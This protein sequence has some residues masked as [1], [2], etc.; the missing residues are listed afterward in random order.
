MKR[1][2]KKV[3]PRR[4]VAPLLPAYHLS[5]AVAA[6]ITNGF[7]ARRLKVIGVTGTNGKTTTVL[8]IASIL[9]AAGYKVGYSTSLELRIGDKVIEEKQ[10]SAAG[11]GTTRDAFILQRL[12]KRMGAAQL[13]WVVLEVTSHA[14]SQH[15]TWGIPVHT[16]VMTNLTEDH[17]DYHGTMQRYM[18]AKGKLFRAARRHSVLNRDDQYFDYFARPGKAA[19][20]SYGRSPKS[21]VRLAKTKLS[22]DGSELEISYGKQRVKATIHLPS[23][24]NIYN[25]LSAAATAQA[26]GISPESIQEGLESLRSIPGRMESIDTT[27][28]FRVIIDYAH[29]PDAFDQLFRSLRPVTKGQLIAVFGGNPQHDYKG[30]GDVAGGKTDVVIVTDDEPEQADPDEIR[31][32]IIAAAKDAGGKQIHDIADRR[33]AIE[34]AVGLAK[35]DDIVLLLCMGSQTYRRVGGKKMPWSD[36]EEAEKALRKAK[37]LK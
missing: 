3:L 30:L 9:R 25:A 16:A 19:V 33:K 35:K 4:F 17:L 24:F 18:A 5:R 15:R 26:L 12:M 13:D 27:K 29:A 31:Q 10:N 37:M 28:G 7:P 8:Y 21:D 22:A 36:R 6:N 2:L 34:K 23:E 1:L 14:L 32:T 20:T 11:P